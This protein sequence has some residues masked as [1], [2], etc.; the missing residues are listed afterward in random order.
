M[1]PGRTPTLHYPHPD[2]A[3][4]GEKGGNHG[5]ATPFPGA[6]QGGASLVQKLPCLAELMKSCT[7][8]SAESPPTGSQP[9]SKT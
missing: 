6:T 7:A 1:F 3:N 4:S 8:M 2:S 9:L 5:E